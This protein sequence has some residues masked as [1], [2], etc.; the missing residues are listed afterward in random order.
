MFSDNIFYII[1]L[2]KRNHFFSLTDQITRCT[3]TAATMF[4]EVSY[5]LS[6]LID[7]IDMG[8]IGLPEIQRPFVWGNAKVRDLFDLMYKRISCRLFSL[9]V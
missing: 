4:K 2:L 3:L 1:H 6:K 8:I 9:L 5:T 7:D